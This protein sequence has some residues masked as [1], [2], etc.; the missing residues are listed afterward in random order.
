VVG[1]LYECLCTNI[2]VEYVNSLVVDQGMQI[3]AGE[4]VDSANIR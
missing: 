3:L 1:L 2:I 4:S